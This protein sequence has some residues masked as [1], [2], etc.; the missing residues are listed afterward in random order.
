MSRN[1]S[2][3]FKSVV[4]FR[5]TGRKKVLSVIQNIVVTAIV[6]KGLDIYA[7]VKYD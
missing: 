3:S 5:Q 4:F 2:L 1:F 6:Q 7:K